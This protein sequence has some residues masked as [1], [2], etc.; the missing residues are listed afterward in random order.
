MEEDD[1]SN[2]IINAAIKV[3]KRLGPGLLESVY[4]KALN[5]ELE[6]MNL[7]VELQKPMKIVY[8]DVTFDN[9]F[10]ADLVIEDKV[11]LE[12]KSVKA[13]EHIHFK[14]LLTYLRLSGK[15]L[16]LLLNFNV[17]V[18]KNGIK[19]VVNGLM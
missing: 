6:K 17:E 3:H 1:L 12:I 10:R 11:I 2:K 8:E 19:R 5:Y 4:E 13:L 16:G 18:M 7:L 9:G 14:Q 15:K